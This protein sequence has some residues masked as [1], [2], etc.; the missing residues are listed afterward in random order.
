MKELIRGSF[1]K[2][3][4]ASIW[5]HGRGQEKGSYGNVKESFI[6]ISYRSVAWT[7]AVTVA[8]QWKGADS[9]P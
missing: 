2:A 8:S 3:V 5:S 4:K 7:S 6:L 1:K 9:S